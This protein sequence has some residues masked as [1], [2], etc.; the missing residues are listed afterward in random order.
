M[1]IIGSRMLSMFMV[2]S[3]A[4]VS[5]ASQQYYDD[6][7]GGAGEGD[8]YQQQEYQGDY[9]G[10]E[11]GGEPGG[12]NLYQNYVEHAEAKAMGKNTGV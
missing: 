4:A 11:D 9:Y 5:V 12:D 3:I 6:Y 7:E 2:A 1:K 10:G 8:Y